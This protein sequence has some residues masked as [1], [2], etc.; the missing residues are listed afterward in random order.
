MFPLSCQIESVKKK[1]INRLLNY[2][3]SKF[4]VNFSNL[5]CTPEPFTAKKEASMW[6]VEHS[7]KLSQSHANEPEGNQISSVPCSIIGYPAVSSF[8]V[9]SRQDTSKAN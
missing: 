6:G 7:I 8:A 1:N 4:N 5:L 9:I 2:A 3:Q